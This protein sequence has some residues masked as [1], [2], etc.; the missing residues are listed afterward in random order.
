VALAGKKRHAYMFW[1]GKGDRKALGKLV[2]GRILLK[3]KAKK[4]DG[5]E[6]YR[7]H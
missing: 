4:W 2:C 7:L 5:N 3:C 6:W 1:W